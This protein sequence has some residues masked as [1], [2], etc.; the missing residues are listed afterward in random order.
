MPATFAA[1]LRVLGELAGRLAPTRVLDLGGGTGAA[2]WAALA[3]WPSVREATVRDFSEPMLRLGRRLAL[4]SGDERLAAAR[5]V[6]GRLD[7]PGVAGAGGADLVTISYVLSELTGEARRTLL[8]EA[9]RAGRAVVVVEPGTTDGYARV[10][11]VRGQ[12]LA[13]G[14][15]LLGPCPHELDCPLPQGDWCHFPVRLQRSARH[16]AAKGAELAY[17]DEKYSWVAARAPLPAEAPHGD[18]DRA[19]ARVLRHPET[20]KG[21]VEFRVCRPDGTVGREL[22]SKRSGA[23]YRQARDTD[24]GDPLPPPPGQTM[25]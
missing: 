9:M 14:W 7:G 17:E 5:F 21:L 24:W 25:P 10:L 3:V 16:R 19:A 15:R 13:A 4:G 2:A 18:P 11:A 20:R 6:S 23:R 22:V 1:N 8:A 12:L